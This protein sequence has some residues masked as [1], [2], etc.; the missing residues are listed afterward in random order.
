MKRLILLSVFSFSAFSLSAFGQLNNPVTTD[1]IIGA[2]GASV[3]A[4]NSVTLSPASGYTAGATGSAFSANTLSLNLINFGTNPVAGGA[5]VLF[6]SDGTNLGYSLPGMPWKTINTSGSR[7]TFSNAAV[8]VTAGTTQLAQTGTMSASRIVTLPAASSYANGA[9]LVVTDESGTLTS[10]NS[11]VLT[12]AGSDTINGATTLTLT[13][14]FAS[15][16]LVSNGVN[17]WSVDIRGVNRGGTGSTDGSITGTG[18]LTLA[19]GG[20]NQNI[21][22]TPSGTGSVVFPVG[23][24]ASPSILIGTSAGIYQRTNGVIT[25][26][27][28]GLY[29]AEFN[30]EGLR[31][32]SKILGFGL[33]IGGNDVAIQRNAAGIVE[34]NSGTAGTFRDIKVRQYL[35]D[36]TITAAGTTGAQTINKGAG[37]IR[38]AASATSLVVTNSLVT[39]T[40]KILLTTQ[41]NDATMTSS[42]AVATSGAFTIYPNAAPT[43][44]TEVYWELRN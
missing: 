7:Q 14:P 33:T 30:P 32:G 17:K 27:L 31:S 41:T 3:I 13:T 11:L 29:T 44:E 12:R 43:A 20:T 15:P 19:A 2:G 37:T 8:T 40:T 28:G 35:L 1:R 22:L 39:A 5:E 34:V 24:P 21:T 4:N 9:T 25:I 23:I 6:G 10:T 18:A 38:F 16:T 26:S 36:S 42:K